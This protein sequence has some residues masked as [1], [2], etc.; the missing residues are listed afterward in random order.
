MSACVCKRERERFCVSERC[1]IN[2]SSER[3]SLFIS[4]AGTIWMASSWAVLRNAPKPWCEGAT[5]A[6]DS[7]VQSPWTVLSWAFLLKLSSSIIAAL[8]AVMW[9]LVCQKLNWG[10]LPFGG[11]HNEALSGGGSVRMWQHP[12]Q[13]IGH[14]QWPIP[15]PWTAGLPSSIFFLLWPSWAPHL[16]RRLW[17]VL[18]YQAHFLLC[19]ANRMH[20]AADFQEVPHP[21]RGLL[22]KWLRHLAV[23]L[24]AW[25]QA[26]GGWKNEAQV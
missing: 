21:S 2:S 1:Q 17:Q 20:S 22:T 6:G 23:V 11:N 8:V 15:I 12:W 25:I 26:K 7:E 5:F 16:P 3:G 13:N 24:K 19:S 10:P 14:A 18:P 9:L 4:Q